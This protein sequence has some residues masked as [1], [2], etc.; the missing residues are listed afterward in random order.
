MNILKIWSKGLIYG[1]P[2]AQNESQL[3]DFLNAH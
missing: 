2:S 3:I 1:K